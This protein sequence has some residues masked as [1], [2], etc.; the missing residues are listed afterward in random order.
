MT[1]NQRK[2]ISQNKLNDLVIKDIYELAQ[3]IKKRDV[4]LLQFESRIK[5]LEKS[6]IKHLIYSTIQRF[7]RLP[8]AIALLKNKLKSLYSNNTIWKK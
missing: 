8:E 7:K 2:Q 4:I 6:G 3:E 5:K 1:N